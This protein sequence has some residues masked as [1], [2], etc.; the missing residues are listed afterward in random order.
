MF[1]SL[2]HDDALIDRTLITAR[3]TLQEMRGAA[4]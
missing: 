1:V 2:A 4:R 3:D